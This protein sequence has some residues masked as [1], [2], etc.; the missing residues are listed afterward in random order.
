MKSIL[1]K[2]QSW[3]R[4]NSR[5][6]NLNSSS[7]NNIVET[8]PTI[9]EKKPTIFGHLWAIATGYNTGGANNSGETRTTEDDYE[10]IK[11]KV[12]FES[13]VRV[14]LIP[15]RI[16]YLAA[17]LMPILWW[18]KND[19]TLFKRSA[20]A[21]LVSFMRLRGISSYKEAMKILYQKDLEIC[22]NEN[23]EK[24]TVEIKIPDSDL[25]QNIIFH[26]NDSITEKTKKDIKKFKT[27]QNE[28]NEKN[29]KIQNEKVENEEKVFQSLQNNENIDDILHPQDSIRGMNIDNDYNLK[30]I[31]D[32]KNEKN[33]EN[34]K[35][36]DMDLSKINDVL[37]EDDQFIAQRGKFSPRSIF[38]GH[39]NDTKD[40]MEDTDNN[41][42]K[43]NNNSNNN[44]N[45]DDNNNDNN[46]DKND[47]DDNN[48]NK[49]NSSIGLIKN[50][51][52]IMNNDDD[53]NLENED[54][55]D[56]Y[57]DIKDVQ[58]IKNGG[59]VKKLHPLA[60]MVE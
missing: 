23:H 33:H 45:N 36:K 9:E 35:I 53:R 17:G 44:D 24:L 25:D 5:E 28:K 32:A 7:S 47:N 52:S 12:H 6:K 20:V 59:G 30:K 40:N 60:Y 41:I 1:T 56:L 37:K 51:K 21:E 49:K 15:S 22:T 31:D 48:N 14:I 54:H 50:D 19:F 11:K 39:D 16:E 42:N 3:R 13:A 46:D 27:V 18:E 43:N 26:K 57:I 34:E 38:Q 58:K 8:W 4:I 55:K 10:K 29:E 2:Q